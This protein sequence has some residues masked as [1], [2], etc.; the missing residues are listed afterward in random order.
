MHIILCNGVYIGSAPNE[1]QALKFAQNRSEK[2][3]K[4]TY[5]VIRG[6]YDPTYEKLY[7]PL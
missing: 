2:F 4:Q 6:V 7:K 1:Q 3:P 5:D